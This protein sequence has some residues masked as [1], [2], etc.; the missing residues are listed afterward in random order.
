MYQ[1]IELSAFRHNSDGSRAFVGYDGG[2]E[3]WI[4]TKT[5][6]RG[7]HVRQQNGSEYFYAKTLRQVSQ[8]LAGKVGR[9][10]ESAPEESAPEESAP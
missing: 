10:E 3:C 1:N 4:I 8:V 9:I 6:P 7:Y 5:L 2:G